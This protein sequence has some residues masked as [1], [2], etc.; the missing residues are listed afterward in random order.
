MQKELELKLVE[1]YPKL[2][3]D[4]GKSEMETCMAWGC[5]CGNGW[6]LIL[7]ELFEKLSKFPDIVLAQVKEKFGTL[8]VYLEGVTSEN[9]TEVYGYVD[10]AT[11]KSSRT[12]ELCGE[13]GRL[14]T[15][16]WFRVTCY[17]CEEK[18]NERLTQRI[19]DDD[20]GYPD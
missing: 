19:F 7:D 15:D 12:C 18:R 14:R 16:G 9:H 10:S 2:F 17:N 13:I 3:E 6:Y 4:Y 20:D 5:E 11:N 8:R 1:K